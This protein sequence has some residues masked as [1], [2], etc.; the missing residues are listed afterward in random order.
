M[1]EIG[2]IAAIIGASVSLCGAVGALLVKAYVSPVR[3]LAAS[4]TKALEHLGELHD[5]ISGDHEARVRFL[6]HSVNTHSI[7]LETLVKSV[8]QLV[9]KID[10]LVSNQLNQR[11]NE[12]T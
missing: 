4:N 3:A 12:D 1:I 7:H 10:L 9:R 2:S 11:H 5:K 6:E 8:D